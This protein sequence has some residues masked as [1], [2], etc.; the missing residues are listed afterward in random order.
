MDT[1]LR[2]PRALVVRSS[3]RADYYLTAP[4]S[5]GIGMWDLLSILS[6]IAFFA[7]AISYVWGCDYL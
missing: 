4:Y 7:I 3:V 2:T 5:T 6:S 1:L